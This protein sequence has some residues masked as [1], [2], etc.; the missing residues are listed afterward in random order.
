MKL[1]GRFAVRSAG[2]S[3]IDYGLLAALIAIVT[4]ATATALGLSSTHPLQPA[5]N[6]LA[7]G[8]R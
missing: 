3:A 4:L 6:G 2:L 8:S 7:A 5:P 1:R